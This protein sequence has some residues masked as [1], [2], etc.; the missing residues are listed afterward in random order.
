MMKYAPVA[1]IKEMGF[2]DTGMGRRGADWV[3][4][5]EYDKAVSKEVG[6]SL[7][8][9]KQKGVALFKDANFRDEVMGWLPGMMDKI[10]WC[11]IWNAVKAETAAK[12]NLKGEELL[13]KA[14]E[15]FTQVIHET[16]VYDSVFSRSENMRSKNPLTQMATAFM[17]EP[18][19]ALNMFIDSVVHAKNGQ[20]K[21]ASRTV[22]ALV[23]SYALNAFLVSFIRAARDDDDK[24]L[25]EKYLVNFVSEFLQNLNP[26]NQIPYLRDIINL[27]KGYD[28]ERSDMSIVADLINMTIQVGKTIAG[29]EEWTDE[30]KKKLTDQLVTLFGV[31]SE[32]SGV[33]VNN[34]I[35]D[36][37]GLRNVLW[38]NTNDRL[39]WDSL[40]NSILKEYD[41]GLLAPFIKTKSNY[42]LYYD[43][44]IRGDG[45]TAERI[46]G[47]LDE[48]KINSRMLKLLKENEDIIN[49]ANS[50]TISAARTLADELVKKGFDEETV[51][52][53]IKGAIAK[54]ETKAE[55]EEKETDS[56]DEIKALLK[57]DKRIE[58]AAQLRAE[59]NKSGW[60]KIR[61][62]LVN[63]GY[64][65]NTV[66]SLIKDEVSKLSQKDEEEDTEETKDNSSEKSEYGAADINASLSNGRI[67]DAQSYL[68]DFYEKNSKV[69]V[70]GAKSAKSTIKSNITSYFKPQYINGDRATRALIRSRLMALKVDGEPLYTE[71]NFNDWLK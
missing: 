58:Q 46:R 35:R 31:I 64:D 65:R 17:A 68:D 56:S 62:E 26:A 29:T 25:E 28:V 32:F 43:A 33:P 39:T 36:A 9:A 12:T 14:G 51:W 71:K 21:N 7:V 27:A 48:S 20:I 67:A 55:T 6:L 22:A 11:H 34:I 69:Y 23:S 53:A 49:A 66:N 3:T 41:K 59:G 57:K 61:D 52:K 1:I 70:N 10:T 15:R 38:R 63:E 45:E 13:K 19:T 54:D 16:Q 60:E 47:G 5:R 37:K 24:N 4:A 42:D 40:W 2:F 44:L 18:T 50:D 30:N 8:N